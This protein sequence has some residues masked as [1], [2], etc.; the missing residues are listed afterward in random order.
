MRALMCQA[1]PIAS[2]GTR[3][4]GSRTVKTRVPGLRP[5]RIP[6]T[7]TMT[8][9]AALPRPVSDAIIVDKIGPGLQT[10]STPSPGGTRSPLERSPVQNLQID[11]QRLWD[12]LM[13][14]A[15]IGETPKGGICRLTLT[16]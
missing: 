14:T 2:V 3:A 7:S 15:R 11:P 12:M 1:G 10:V 16:D 13:D 6:D 8:S 4:T 9:G 5:A